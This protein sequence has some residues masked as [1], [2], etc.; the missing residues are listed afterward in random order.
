MDEIDDTI[1]INHMDG[2]AMK[3]HR[4]GESRRPWILLTTWLRL[5][6]LDYTWVIFH[7]IRATLT[8]AS[9]MNLIL[10]EKWNILRLFSNILKFPL[11][12]FIKKI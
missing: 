7:S 5:T 4:M 11:H 6:N 9:L 2:I 1:E 8:H 10:V 12:F 3:H